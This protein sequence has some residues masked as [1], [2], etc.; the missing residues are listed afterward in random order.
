MIPTLCAALLLWTAGVQKNPTGG[1]AGAHQVYSPACSAW[2]SETTPPPTIRVLIT[3]T[4][5]VVT[6]PFQLY[7]SRVV[8]VE[9]NFVPLALRKAGAVAVKLYAWHRVIR[10]SGRSHNGHCFHVY[11]GVRD[12]LYRVKD[13]R[14]EVWQAVRATWSWRVLRQGH[15]VFTSYRTGRRVPCASDVDGHRLY[16]RSAWRCA[17][18]GWSASRILAT[19]YEGRVDRG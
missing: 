1:T 14:P 17:L 4:G 5:R 13:P 11:D 8:S 3:R 6:V 16:A 10:W 12:Q 2:H 15:L 19:Y 9:F 18:S 7:V